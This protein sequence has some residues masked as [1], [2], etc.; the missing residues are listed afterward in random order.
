MARYV[1]QFSGVNYAEAY[2]GEHVEFFTSIEHAKEFLQDQPMTET[3]DRVILWA[4]DAHDS[5]AEAAE[6]TLSDVAEADRVLTLGPFGG[7]KVERI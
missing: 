1:G 7:V 3:G 5:R 6:R 4:T 2:P